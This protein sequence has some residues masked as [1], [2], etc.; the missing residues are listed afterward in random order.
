MILYGNPLGALHTE[1]KCNS[2]LPPPVAKLANKLTEWA[3]VKASRQKSEN[4]AGTLITSDQFWKLFEA[5]SFKIRVSSSSTLFK[6]GVLFIYS[7]T[8]YHNYTKWD[9][10][11]GNI[12]LPE[13]QLCHY[14]SLPYKNM[15]LLLCST[16]SCFTAAGQDLP[17]EVALHR[18]QQ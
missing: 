3:N 18:S 17:N 2:S 1:L 13:L 5:E 4:G 12:V 10:V 7:H 15:P 16:R 14:I 8:N 6:F 9:K 11:Q